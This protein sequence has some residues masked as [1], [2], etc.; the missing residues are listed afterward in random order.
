MPEG[1]SIVFNKRGELYQEFNYTYPAP[2]TVGKHRFGSCDHYLLFRE[3]A[4]TPIEKDIQRCQNAESARILCRGVQP[5]YNWEE[6]RDT[7]MKTALNAK[8]KQREYRE[9]LLSTETKELVFHNKDKYWGDGG[10]DG[11]GQNRLGKLLMQ[12]RNE[13]KQPQCM[14][15]PITP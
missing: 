14:T 1:G 15:R 11:G 7:S 6:N 5:K 12:L 10:L 2:I 9:L 4:G 13:L 8:F 3:Y